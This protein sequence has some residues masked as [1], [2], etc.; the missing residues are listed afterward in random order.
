MGKKLIKEAVYLYQLFCA[1]LIITNAGFKVADEQAPLDAVLH[2]MVLV[3]IKSC[4]EGY[5]LWFK[6]KNLL[7]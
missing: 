6:I 4:T 3:T 7:L 1:I 5:L 2:N